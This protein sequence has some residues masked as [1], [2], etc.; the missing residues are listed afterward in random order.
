MV[1]TP[2][3]GVARR[4]EVELRPSCLLVCD[5]QSHTTRNRRVVLTEH[6]YFSVARNGREVSSAHCSC[7]LQNLP[8]RSMMTFSVNVLE[9]R[10][11][12]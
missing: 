7:S 1:R 5:S 10:L 3:K 4:K 11:C 6:R 8:E 9:R 2:H 12:A